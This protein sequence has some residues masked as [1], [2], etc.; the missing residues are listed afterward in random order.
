MAILPAA[1][2]QAFHEGGFGMRLILFALLVSL[3]LIADRVL[4]VLRSVIN[5]PRFATDVR[6]RL[7]GGDIAGALQVCHAVDRPLSRVLAAGL[8]HSSEGERRVLAAMD[9]AAYR[10]VPEI[11]KRTGYLA[12]MG[13]VATLMGLFGTIIGLIHSFGAVSMSSTTENATLLAAGISEAMNCTAFGLLSGILALAAF[14]ALNGRTQALIDQVNYYTLSLYRVWKRAAQKQAG[15]QPV[16]LKN[17]IRE[18]H[19]HLMASTGLLKAKGHG[20]GKKSTFAALQLTPLIDMFI[21]LVIFLLLNFSATGQIV[22]ANKDIKLP[23][24]EKV[25]ELKR[26]PIVSISNMPDHP[27]RGIVT[28]E[29]REV[30]TVAELQE[31]NGPDWQIPKLTTQLEQRKNAWNR[32]NPDKPFAGEL[33]VQCDQDIDFQVI[34]KVMYSAGLAGYGNLL[35]AVQKR[36]EKSG[37]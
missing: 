20:R 28:L 10:E 12:L 26:V 11:E 3:W 14:S 16:F 4:M 24:A 18:P 15:H 2:A 32:T 5:A 36:A 29:N 19:P 6:S 1:V 21:V 9:E 7:E 17:P 25:E 37:G 35:F 27:T 33:I 23:F 34:K 31:D 8:K 13:N 30:A 22:T